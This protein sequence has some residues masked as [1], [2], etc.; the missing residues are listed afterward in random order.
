M[1]MMRR[2]INASM[3]SILGLGLLA[4]PAFA[5]D[6]PAEPPKEEPKKEEAP[7]VAGGEAPMEI[8]K[9]PLTIQASKIEIGGIHNH[10]TGFV[11]NLTS[12]LEAKANLLALGVAYGLSDKMQLSLYTT[13]LCFPDCGD[14]FRDVSVGFH[15]LLMGEGTFQA[16]LHGDVNLGPFSGDFGFGVTIGA[17]ARYSAGMLAIV[18]DFQLPLH[19]SPSPAAVG[20]N[21]PIWLEFQVSPNLTPFVYVNFNVPTFDGFGDVWGL[22]LGIGAWYSLNKMIDLGL[23]FTFPRIVGGNSSGSADFRNVGLWVAIRP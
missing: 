22:G 11:L 13:G 8:T 19:F 12:G 15:Y 2:L 9:R 23:T 18:F 3:V 21:L 7:P 14:A 16:A 17:L 1:F 20:I 6:P 4:G 10:Q 5:Q